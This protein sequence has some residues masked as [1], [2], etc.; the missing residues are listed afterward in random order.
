MVVAPEG[1]VCLSMT[2]V[3]TVREWVANLNQ[4]V[5]IDEMGLVGS[6]EMSFLGGQTESNAH[7]V[8]YVVR[9]D[10]AQYTLKL[11]VAEYV[12]SPCVVGSQKESNA[13]M[14]VMYVVRFDGAQYKRSGFV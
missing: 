6:N 14:V 8:M 12:V 3:A 1:V 11:G 9:F 2:M 7:M 13:D 4:I 5:G 10:R